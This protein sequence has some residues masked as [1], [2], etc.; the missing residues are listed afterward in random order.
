MGSVK[1]IVGIDLG[2]SFSG[3]AFASVDKPKDIRL[4]SNWSNTF[5]AYKAP[6]AVL[7]AADQLLGFGYNAYEEY[8]R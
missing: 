7:L 3:F 2:T 8:E 5:T 1:Y 4:N 6:S